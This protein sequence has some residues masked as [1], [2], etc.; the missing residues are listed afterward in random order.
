MKNHPN[1]IATQ[2]R[3]DRDGLPGRQSCAINTNQAAL[4]LGTLEVWSQEQSPEYKGR[5]FFV[6]DPEE[7]RMVVKIDLAAKEDIAPRYQEGI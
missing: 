5:Q 6:L 7:T 4:G 3:S 2:I 1:L